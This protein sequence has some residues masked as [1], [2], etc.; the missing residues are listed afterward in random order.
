[1]DAP[2]KSNRNAMPR[3]ERVRGV[4]PLF[5]GSFDPFDPFGLIDRSPAM[6]PARRAMSRSRPTTGRPSVRQ[7]SV[8]WQLHHP[9][10]DRVGIELD[11]ARQC[12]ASRSHWRAPMAELPC[13]VFVRHCVAKS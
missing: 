2:S 1:L 8:A 13:R 12:E 5:L 4:T 10:E 6:V 7:A 3:R 11:A 9:G